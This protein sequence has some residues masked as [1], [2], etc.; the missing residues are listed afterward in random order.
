M[1][2]SQL[3]FHP[4]RYTQQFDRPFSFEELYKYPGDLSNHD[5]G[6]SRKLI[7]IIGGGIAGVTSAYELSQLGHQ[8]IILEAAPRLGGRIRT[9]YFNDGTYSEMGAMRIP[10]NHRCTLHYVEKFNLARRPFISYNPSAFYHLRGQKTHLDAYR[11]LFSAYALRPEEHEDPSLLYEKPLRELL[12]TLSDVE[13]WEMFS[14]IFTSDRLKQYDHISFA[15]YFRD[16]LSPEAF[17]MVGHATGMIHYEQVSLLGGLIDFF[18]W[19]RADQYELVGGME[20]LVNAFVKNLSGEILCNAKVTSMEMTEKGVLVRWN[21]LDRPDEKQFDYVICTVP[22]TALASIEFH[23]DLPSNQREAMGGLTY[24]SSVKTLFHCTARPWEIHDRIYGG[25]SFTDL[26]IQ[27]C[28][29]PSDNAKPANSNVESTP[30][31][32]A[33]TLIARDPE[34]SHQPAVLTAAYRWEENSRR[35]LQLNDEERINSS[36]SGSKMLHPQIDQYVDQIIHCPWDEQVAPGSGAYAFF[37]PGDHERYQQPL[38]QPYPLDQPR[39]FFAGEH[40]AINHASVQGAI[41]TAVAAAIEV[42]SAPAPFKE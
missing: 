35:F 20:T 40:L 34:L 9:H 4:Y 15:Q 18:S 3:N 37:K 25:G 39:V 17:E 22:A 7:A 11:E 42:L 30:T 5:R 2:T 26:P 28:W 14:P 36:L 27:Q 16:R 23:P 31:Q 32:T 6:G 19:Y 38:C 33:P 1:E 8:V 12:E 21:C 13:K 29:Y 10:M 41:H 24:G